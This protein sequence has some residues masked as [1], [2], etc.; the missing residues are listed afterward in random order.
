MLERYYRIRSTATRIEALRHH[1][2]PSAKTVEER[3]TLIDWV[4]A[5]RSTMQII[6]GEL[7]T[8]LEAARRLHE[9]L[10]SSRLH[11][12]PGGPHNAYWEMP[13]A[14]NAVAGEF[15]EGVT[16]GVAAD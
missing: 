15:L 4:T 14:W 9:L 13:E 3:A 11:V 5:I 7:D 8:A 12:I 2:R 16:A 1:R 10:P 6:T